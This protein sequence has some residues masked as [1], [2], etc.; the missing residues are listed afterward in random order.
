VVLVRLF[1]LLPPDGV[2]FL[3]P[4]TTSLSLIHSRSLDMSV[5]PTQVLGDQTPHDHG[6]TWLTVESGGMH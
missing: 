5:S 4:Y 3:L 2:A 1:L 6:D